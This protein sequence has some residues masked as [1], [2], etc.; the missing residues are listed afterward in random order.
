M[1]TIH[2]DNTPRCYMNAVHELSE[3]TITLDEFFTRCLAHYGPTGQRVHH[4]PD[5]CNI[6]TS[7]KCLMTEGKEFGLLAGAMKACE[8][9]PLAYSYTNVDALSQVMCCRPRQCEEP[10]IKHVKTICSAS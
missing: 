2:Y 6:G 1:E 3:Q 7:V 5:D 4:P 9:D 10:T 8:T